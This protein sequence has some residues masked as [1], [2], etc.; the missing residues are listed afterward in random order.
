MLLYQEWY[1]PSRPEPALTKGQQLVLLSSFG[2]LHPTEMPEIVAALGRLEP[3]GQV[4]DLGGMLGDRLKTLRVKEGQKVEKGEVLGYLDSHDER[5]AEREAYSAQ[6]ADARAR[7]EAEVAYANAQIAEAEVG[8]DQAQRLSPLDI[9]AQEARVRLLETE[10]AAAQ[11]DQARL[12]SLRLPSSVPAQKREQ[13]DQLVR[14]AGE[15]LKAAQATLAKARVGQELGEAKARAQMEA[16]RAGRKRAEASAQIDSLTKQ[17]A[18]ADAR[19]E[20]T[21]LRAPCTGTILEI[22]ARPGERVDQQPALRLGDTSTMYIVAEVYETDILQV[23]P[24][25][26][27]QATSPALT[28]PLTGTVE[29]IGHMV[30]RNRILSVDPAAAAD[31]RVIRVWIRLDSAGPASKLTNL[32]VDVKI[33]RTGELP[34]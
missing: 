32:Q 19:V 24:G 18:L 22:L 31:A 13:Q 4:I 12:N 17:V 16:A 14:R 23:K 1:P 27:A 7:L 30:G 2:K 6:L 8:L 29:R 5:K 28:Q 10:L 34:S 20:R 21:I 11:A 9:R 25:Q 3:S 15:E 33:S 26:R